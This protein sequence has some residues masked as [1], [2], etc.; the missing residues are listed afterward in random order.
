M[1]THMENN[2][3][4]IFST[5]E[6][7]EEFLTALNRIFSNIQFSYFE[8]NDIVIE[9]FLNNVNTISTDIIDN[10]CLPVRFQKQVFNIWEYFSFYLKRNY[11]CNLYI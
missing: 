2:K 9:D 1:N 7:L 3:E 4:A 5:P 6:T 10:P 8:M 11:I